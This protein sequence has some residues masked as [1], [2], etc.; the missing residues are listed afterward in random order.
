MGIT[1][2]YGIVDT[3]GGQTQDA[4]YLIQNDGTVIQEVYVYLA[5][6]G[7]LPYFYYMNDE[8]AAMDSGVDVGDAWYFNSVYYDGDYLYWSA[9]ETDVA[10]DVTLYAIDAD[11]SGN[12]YEMGKFAPTVWPVGGLHELGVTPTLDVYSVATEEMENLNV[13]IA[14]NGAPELPQYVLEARQVNAGTPG[15]VNSAAGYQPAEQPLS[16]TET[17][18]NEGTVTVTVTAKDATGT[19]VASTNG[20]STVTY[21]AENLTLVSI[22]VEG[23]YVSVKK[24]DGSVTFGYVE[25]DGFAAG[26]TV[27]TLVFEAKS[28]DKDTITVDHEEVSDET[29]GYEEELIYGCDHENTELVDD[30]EASCTKEG[31]TGDTVCTDCGHVVEE[32]EPIP[33]DDHDYESVVTPPTVE[34]GGYTTHTC[35]VCGD[36]YVDS[37]TPA[38]DPDNPDT[39]DRFN[40]ALLITVMLLSLAGAAC[41]VIVGKKQKSF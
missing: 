4:V 28:T 34:A 14:E 6:Y 15:G 39:G 25:L 40:P 11:Y 35:K 3:E 41:L 30:E 5:D 12:V 32:G 31:Y 23:D 10:D 8:R 13:Y 20:V 38:L 27:A 22:K 33:M 21:D 9:H 1:T 24:S 2:C 29:P 18:K 36:S 17:D 19:D 16:D 7:V 37:F 26:D